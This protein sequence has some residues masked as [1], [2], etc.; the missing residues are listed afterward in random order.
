[1]EN[2][3]EEN[4]K[5]IAIFLEEASTFFNFIQ[6]SFSLK[7]IIM[8]VFFLP[9]VA[10]TVVVVVVHSFTLENDARCVETSRLSL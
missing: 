4:T 10:L 9:V 6:H 1:M 8:F 5:A 2:F 3:D 7:L